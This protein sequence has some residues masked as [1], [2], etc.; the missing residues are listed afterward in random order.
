M[1]LATFVLNNTTVVLRRAERDDVAALVSMITSDSIAHARGD[2]PGADLQPYLDAFAAI[3]SDPAQLLIV[4]DRDGE[5]VGTLQLS[6]IPG[7]ARRGALRAQIEA[8]RVRDDQRGL[9]LGA[10]MLR[11]SV[12]EARLRGCA[13]VQL[14][15]DRKRPAAHEFYRKLG[16]TPTHVGFKLDL[17]A[18]AHMA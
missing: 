2:A 9:G 15:S 14:T 10:A 13:L 5:A 3:D 6:F 8:V 1:A 7:L 4:A 11:W 16:F 18:P 17:T 12:A